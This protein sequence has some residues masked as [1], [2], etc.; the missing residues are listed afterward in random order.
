M[1][2]RETKQQ[3]Q[4]LDESHSCTVP[5]AFLFDFGG[6]IA[7]EGFREGLK[8]IAARQG[9]D[10]EIVQRMAPQTAYD[11]GYVLGRGTEADFWALMRERAGLKG[12]D[13]EL[14]AEI[15]GR[16][17]LR[18]RMVEVVR[19][20]RGQEFIVA[21]LSDQTDWLEQLDR[22]YHFYREFDR[23]FN[24]YRRGKGKH[25]PSLFADV[26]VELGVAPQAA[27]FVD[28]DPANVDRAKSQGLQAALFRS[29]EEFIAELEA[30]LRPGT[31]CGPL[32]P[33]V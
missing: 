30:I 33:K 4:H 22:K 23:V 29:E 17:T 2:Q 14:T 31:S 7:A 12:T 8:A 3:R 5:R 16:F 1:I 21:I 26:V 9:L 10:P 32:S 20:L 24:S 13:E 15:I 18:P 11:S 19:Q 25:D 6:V 27:F 28:D